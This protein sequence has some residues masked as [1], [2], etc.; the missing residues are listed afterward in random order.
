MGD[1]HKDPLRQERVVGAVELPPRL[2]QGGAGSLPPGQALEVCLRIPEQLEVEVLSVRGKGAILAHMQCH[3]RA[4]SA[5]VT[6]SV[7]GDQRAAHPQL[8]WFSVRKRGA[9]RS[10]PG[11]APPVSF[12]TACA[13][14]P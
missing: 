12:V 9:N 2:R 11:A 7:P 4:S 5:M 1:R 10:L 3:G 14:N 6:A 13:R 8:L